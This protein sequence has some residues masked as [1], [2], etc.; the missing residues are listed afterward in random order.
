MQHGLQLF[1]GSE[2]MAL[3][4]LLDPT[5]EAFDHAVCLR[6]FRR[7]QAV[8]DVQVGTGLVELVLARRGALALTD[9][10]LC[11]HPGWNI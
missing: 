1:A 6:R 4:H 9:E 10:G 7:G 3:K 8:L 11:D 2:V 5:V